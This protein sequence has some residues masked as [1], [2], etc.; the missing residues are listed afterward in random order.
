MMAKLKSDLNVKIGNLDLKNPLMTAS[1]T[2]GYG[3]E[4]DEYLDISTLR[5]VVT[6]SLTLKPKIGNEPPRITE[7]T[8]GMI[9]SI[10]LANIGVEKFIVQ[11]LPKLQKEDV[12]IIA[13]IAAKRVEDYVLLAERLAAFND[14]KGLS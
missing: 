9:N 3:D 13:N 8:S 12:V 6:K 7:V 1:G 10:G 4:L 11:K 5:A 14:I 2:C